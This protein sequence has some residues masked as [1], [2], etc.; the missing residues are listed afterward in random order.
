[1]RLLLPVLVVACASF[2][3]EAESTAPPPRAQHASPGAAPVEPPP[4]P[5]APEPEPRA[6]LAQHMADHF[7]IALQARDAVI[8]GEPDGARGALIWL[9]QHSYSGEVPDAWAEW[10]RAMQAAA[11]VARDSDNLR[12]QAA[13]VANMAAR[14]AD[15]HRAQQ[16]KVAFEPAGFEEALEPNPTE[17]LQDRMHR[18]LWAAE[19]MWE[20]LIADD[21]GRY[22]AGAAVLAEAPPTG[23]ADPGL[24]AHLKAV[25]ELGL[26][27]RKATTGEGRTNLYAEFLSRCAA[28]HS[29]RAVRP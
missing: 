23:G 29:E 16:A 14:C 2:A 21:P 22:A 5:P 1:M 15:C 11:A 4:V 18:H 3:C 20:G 25:Q 28:C 12:V 6:E 26:R 27:A 7:G 10:V 19:R 24:G 9:A 13:A 8:R 17:P